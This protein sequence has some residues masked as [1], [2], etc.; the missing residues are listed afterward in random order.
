MIDD[1]ELIIVKNTHT[2][3]LRYP[4]VF[5][6]LLFV[7]ITERPDLFFLTFRGYEM[8]PFVRIITLGRPLIFDE[9]INFVEWVVYEHHKLNASGFATKVFKWFY[10]I[11]LISADLIVTDSPS[12]AQ[13][14][15]ELMH[16][17]MK[18]YQSLIVSTDEET[19]RVTTKKLPTF[20]PHTFNV[21]YYGNML[22]LHGISTVIEAMKLLKGEDI[23]LAMIGGKENVQDQVAVA[24]EDG[25]A[26][27]YLKWVPYDVL[28]SYMEAADVCLG[29]PFGGTVQSQF[30]ITGKTY[31]LLHMGRPTIVG[32][33]HES[34]LFTDKENALLVEQANPRALADTI[35]WAKAHP[36]ELSKIGDAG[37]KLYTKKFS[38]VQ[39][40]DELRLLLANEQIL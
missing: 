1:V 40:A 18:K 32:R 37:K 5:L 12:H 4:E 34:S 19:F 16:I 28:P 6:R 21:F 17:P 3:I 35:L 31:Q 22:P 20:E 30:V 7:R 10:R 33:N 26:I 27:E 2:G 15:S 23:V 13:Y 29:G 36:L 14:S 39:L 8:L 38:N 11:A 25:I 24:K 9:F